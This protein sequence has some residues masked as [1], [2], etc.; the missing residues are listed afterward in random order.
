M[1]DFGKREVLLEYFDEGR[2]FHYNMGNYPIDYERYRPLGRCSIDKA[3]VFCM[4]VQPF[5][6]KRNANTPIVSFEIMKESWDEFCN[7]EERKK[8]S[9]L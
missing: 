8:L 1:E 9:I 7:L 6:T 5:I 3:D 2:H 4:I